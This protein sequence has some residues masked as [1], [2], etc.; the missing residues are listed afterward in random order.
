MMRTKPMTKLDIGVTL[1]VGVLQ[2]LGAYFA[3]TA[4]GVLGIFTGLALSLTTLGSMIIAE[5]F[6][7]QYIKENIG[8]EEEE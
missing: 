1:G 4:G 3:F 6:H 7:V 5:I 2:A 8:G